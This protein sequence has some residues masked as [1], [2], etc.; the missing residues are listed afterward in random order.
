VAHR[1]ID[2]LSRGKVA[3][4]WTVQPIT[5]G[6]EGYVLSFEG[7]RAFSITFRSGNLIVRINGDRRADVEE[8]ASLA[9][10]VVK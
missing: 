5:R 7:G 8:L 10:Q 4:G 6:E 2:A 3:S 1:W 9:E